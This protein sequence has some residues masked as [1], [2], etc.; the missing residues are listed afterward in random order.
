M[1]AYLCSFASGIPDTYKAHIPILGVSRYIGAQDEFSSSKS[2]TWWIEGQV[3]KLTLR[4]DLI[5]KEK[6]R[7]DWNGEGED[8]R[9][10]LADESKLILGTRASPIWVRK[11]PDFTCSQ[12][13]PEFYKDYANF[14]I[15]AIDRYHPWAIEL[16]NEPE[17]Q[18]GV[19]EDNWFYMGCWDSGREY[20]E[21]TKV[22]YPIIKEKHPETLVMIG[23]LL[24][25]DYEWIEEMFAENPSGDT[26]S[27]HAYDYYFGETGNAKKNAL[28][29]YE[30]TD[31]PLFLSETALLDMSLECSADFQVAKRE[32]LDSLYKSIQDIG[33]IGFTWY[34]IGGNLWRCSD[35]YPGAAYDLYK[36]L[37]VK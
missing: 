4:W 9:I 25:E 28:W 10:F 26:V 14:I 36:E 1:F 19:F 20:A 17:V 24:M 21:M 23:A 33:I 27:Y 12:P 15:S 32:Y 37:I 5:E 8:S 11:H 29:L 22:V 7:Y 3:T 13:T 35:L 6:G 31:K 34:T 16:W 2:Y 30:H 18:K